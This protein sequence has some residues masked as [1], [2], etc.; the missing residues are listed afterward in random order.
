MR[1][2]RGR[3]GTRNEKIKITN[4]VTT[5]QPLLRVP[6]PPRETSAYVAFIILQLTVLYVRLNKEG[7]SVPLHLPRFS[8]SMS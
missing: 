2:D 7:P 8:R 5:R 6:D 1:L 4:T 3:R